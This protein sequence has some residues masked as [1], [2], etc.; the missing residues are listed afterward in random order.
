ML[1]GEW[2]ARSV[3]LA[4]A[5]I[6]VLSLAVVACGG[7]DDSGAGG[8]EGGSGPDTVTGDDRAPAPGDDLAETGSAEGAHDDGSA[9]K[10]AAVDCPVTSLMFD[11]E[12]AGLAGTATTALAR[13]SFDGGLYEVHVADF[14]LTPDD[15]RSWRP[16]VPD[17]ANVI[18]VQ[19][20]VFNASEDPAPID[21]GTTLDVTI[22]PGELTYIV[23][24][25]TADEDWSTATNI[26]TE[27]LGTM[28]VTEV[29]DVFCFDIDYHDQDKRID[30]SVAAVVFERR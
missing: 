14:D 30:G 27:T 6:G 12:A 7:D 24:H 8:A 15:V 17:G 29:G 1:R 10:V 5:I 9:D 22:D 13:S 19:L 3:R 2:G 28:T 26:G 18:T 23:R 21:A 4:T 16:E 11:N 25:F 20:T